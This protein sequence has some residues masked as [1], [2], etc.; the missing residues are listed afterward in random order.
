M[1]NYIHAWANPTAQTVTGRAA[2]A[3]IG[4]IRF[5]IAF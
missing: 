1:A 2:E 4:Q 5:Q 3:D